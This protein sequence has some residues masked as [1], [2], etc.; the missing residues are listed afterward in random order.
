MIEATIERLEIDPFEVLCLFAKG[1]WESLGYSGETKI[2]F[3]AAG[4]EFDEYLIPP[5]LRFSAAKEA[6][7]YVYS[8]KKAVEHTSVNSLEGMN[9]EQRLEAMKHAVKMLEL[10][11]HGSGTS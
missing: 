6:A 5:E 11:V 3:T 2:S 7:K 8:Q 10:E 4:I 1:D 9:P